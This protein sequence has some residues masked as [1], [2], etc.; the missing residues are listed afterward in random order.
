MQSRAATTVLWLFRRSPVTD[1]RRNVV[2]TVC[3]Q[4]A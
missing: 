3:R 1:M 4:Q 2:T